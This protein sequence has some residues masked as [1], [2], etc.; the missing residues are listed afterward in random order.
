MRATEPRQGL[1]ALSGTV[2]RSAAAAFVVVTAVL[3]IGAGVASADTR[4]GFV[5]TVTC[6]STTTT[7]VSPTDPAAASQDVSSTGVIILA[8]GAIHAPSSFPSDKVVFCDLV[9]LTTGSSFQDVPFLI[10]GAP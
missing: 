9:N 4:T 2:K 5:L 6:G 10:Q 3:V 1:R 7:V 8:Y